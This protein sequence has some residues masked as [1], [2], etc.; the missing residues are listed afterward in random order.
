MR[1]NSD[2]SSNVNQARKT[3]GSFVWLFNFPTSKI[4]LSNRCSIEKL[5]ARIDDIRASL[6]QTL[7][8]LAK[9]ANVHDVEL[10][11]KK[12]SLEFMAFMHKLNSQETYAFDEFTS[13]MNQQKFSMKQLIA[14]F[15][16][17][18][19]SFLK[20]HANQ[21]STLYS[22]TSPNQTIQVDSQMKNDTDTQ[23]IE[24]SDLTIQLS[25]IPA[26]IPISTASTPVGMSALKMIDNDGSQLGMKIESFYLEYLYE[27]PTFQKARFEN[28]NIK[29]SQFG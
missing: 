6:V 26:E 21:T 8:L 10:I 11:E 4:Q 13:L 18:V 3:S 25:S 7:A 19:S 29:N 23:T 28:N 5:I 1:V 20:K 17:R 9:F 12:M 27:K 15:L 16:G 14:T 2:Q 24:N 22:T